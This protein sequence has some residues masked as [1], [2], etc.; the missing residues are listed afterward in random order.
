MG[1]CH[2]WHSIGKRTYWY[3]SPSQRLVYLLGVIRKV[4]TVHYVL[5]YGYSIS[6]PVQDLHPLPLPWKRSAH[7]LQVV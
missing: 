5:L 4:R 7:L 1:Y 2:C 3:Y 6:L